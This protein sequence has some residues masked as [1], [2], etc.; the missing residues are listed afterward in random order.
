M[1]F[2]EGFLKELFGLCM[3]LE[4]TASGTFRRAFPLGRMPHSTASEY[5]SVF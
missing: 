1:R 3:I 2:F 4:E 5:A